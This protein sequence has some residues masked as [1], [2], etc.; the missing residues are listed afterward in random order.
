MQRSLPAAVGPRTFRFDST[1]RYKALQVGDDQ[2]QAIA[3]YEAEFALPVHYMLYHP[4][5]IPSE[6]AIPVSLPYAPPKEPIVVG[7]RVMAAASMRALATTFPRNYAPA[8]SE[9][10]DDRSQLG[11]NLPG[12]MVK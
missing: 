6:A 3:N 8:F 10:K 1:C 4:R 7:T 5:S 9:I 2:W 11:I 12:F